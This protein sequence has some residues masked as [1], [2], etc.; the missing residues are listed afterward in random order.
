MRPVVQDAQMQQWGLRYAAAARAFAGQKGPGRPGCLA[1]RRP[2]P[3]TR[4]PAGSVLRRVVRPHPGGTARHDRGARVRWSHRSCH[5]SV[6]SSGYLVVA[7]FPRSFAEVTSGP[8][9]GP[10]PRC[11]AKP[12]RPPSS[13]YPSRLFVSSAVD[14]LTGSRPGRAGPVGAPGEGTS[15][16]CGPALAGS[17]WSMAGGMIRPLARHL[18]GGG[19]SPL[20]RSWRLGGG[21][22]QSWV[23]RCLR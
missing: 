5:H 11:G 20:P 15:W 22:Y 7:A 16:A 8:V 13:K 4:P 23:G 1:A 14:H 10:G 2:R 12:R 21:R 3:P 6:S 17:A 18:R 19:S 9:V